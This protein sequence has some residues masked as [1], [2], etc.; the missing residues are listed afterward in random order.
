MANVKEAVVE[1][2]LY[3]RDLVF[4]A[5]CAAQRINGA[6]VKPTDHARFVNHIYGHARPNAISTA[7]EVNATKLYNSAIMK[8][9]LASDRS[10][11]LPQDYIRAE[12]VIAHFC[13]MITL[14]FSG[15]ARDFIKDA[16]EPPSG[17]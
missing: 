13:S 6:Y 3:P 9:I 2:I 16:P 12:E 1:P 4:A 5:A 8:T 15:E 7:V 11:I 10:D 14:V 17:F